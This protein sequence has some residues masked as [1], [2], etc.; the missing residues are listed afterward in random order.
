MKNRDESF[1]PFVNIFF[2][3]K[4]MIVQRFGNLRKNCGKE[5][6]KISLN[7]EKNFMSLLGPRRRTNIY[8][9]FKSVVAVALF[10]RIKQN[11]AHV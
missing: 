7:E 1:L 11:F 10:V 4:D 9:K 3:S 5:N 6:V 8:R 2:H